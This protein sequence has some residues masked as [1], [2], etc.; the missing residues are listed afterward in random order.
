MRPGHRITFSRGLTTKGNHAKSHIPSCENFFGYLKAKVCHMTCTS[1]I[2][3]VTR[4]ELGN[5]FQKRNVR[6]L[7]SLSSSTAVCLLPSA[8]YLK[9]V[10]VQVLLSHFPPWINH[11]YWLRLPRC[12]KA[13]GMH[14]ASLP[15]GVTVLPAPR[16]PALRAHC[17]SHRINST[18]SHSLSTAKKN[19]SVL[20]LG[21]QH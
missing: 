21:T 13:V 19:R 15:G 16:A 7:R 10:V 14:C 11:L 8:E 6:K 17:L 3:S 9:G 5:F 12:L 20:K 2:F 1:T 18:L 4:H